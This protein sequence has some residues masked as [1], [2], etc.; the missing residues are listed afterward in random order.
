MFL[1]GPNIATRVRGAFLSL[2]VASVATWASAANLTPETLS[3]WWS[4]KSVSEKSGNSAMWE[5]FCQI[6][7]QRLTV[8]G[9]SFGDGIF[10][11]VDC[12]P[13]GATPS[14]TPWRLMV[15]VAEDGLTLKL[16]RLVRFSTPT[17]EGDKVR[18]KFLEAS[19]LTLPTGGKTLKGL[20]GKGVPSLVARR[21]L[22]GMPMGWWLDEKSL[23]AD[24]KQIS[25]AAPDS[26]FDN[27]LTPPAE[28]VFFLARLDE[29]RQLWI[30][31]V[32]GRATTRREGKRLIW[33]VPET[34]ASAVRQGGV[35]AQNWSGRGQ[36]SQDLELALRRVYEPAA[37]IGK[38][39]GGNLTK[40]F[41]NTG[42]RANRIGL[43][44]GASILPGEEL[45]QQQRMYGLF[46]DMRHGP[47]AGWRVFADQIP[48]VTSSD[49]MSYQSD[50]YL[51]GFAITLAPGIVIRQIDVT[52]R[53]GFWNVESRVIALAGI[54][55]DR[56]LF[57]DFNVQRAGSGGVEA[58]VEFGDAMSAFRLWAS[59]DRGINLLS[60]DGPSSEA[61]RVGL[62][63]FM[64]LIPLGHL[65]ATDLQAIIQAFGFLE[66]VTLTRSADSSELAT[67]TFGFLD[68]FVG[69]GVGVT[70]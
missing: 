11:K 68:A 7:G 60:P 22:D 23:S 59:L 70:W 2:L 63:L 39:T 44:Y 4:S 18:S 30:P 14:A 47:Y 24:S 21:L 61:R 28:L 3:I 66:Q 54:D 32:L 5:K 31:D 46:A 62:D 51:L 57:A 48:K 20:L 37:G 10:D 13:I 55:G 12:V 58:G 9:G 65:G 29:H 34:V 38:S 1:A 56:P 36:Q 15:R 26:L 19:S 67:T 33:I 50:R 17:P 49:G 43:R 6:L 42:K 8:G 40:S 53:L 69:A 27:S 35:W 25:I 41:W 52:P 64:P 16:Y 45:I